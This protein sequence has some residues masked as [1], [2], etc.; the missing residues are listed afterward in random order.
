[1]EVMDA[2]GELVVEDRSHN[3]GVGGMIRRFG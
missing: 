2:H 1:M 3:S